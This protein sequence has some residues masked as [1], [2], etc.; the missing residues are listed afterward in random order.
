MKQYDLSF[1]DEPSR[2]RVRDRLAQMET[3][4]WDRPVNVTAYDT[5]SLA[6]LSVLAEEIIFSQGLAGVAARRA[7][8]YYF[9][10]FTPGEASHKW[11][12]DHI[13]NAKVSLVKSTRIST[14]HVNPYRESTQWVT[15]FFDV[16][17]GRCRGVLIP[18]VNPTPKFFEGVGAVET[19]L[20][21]EKQAPY[22]LGEQIIFRIL[23]S[24]LGYSYR[25]SWMEE[26]GI[27]KL[28][29]EAAKAVPITFTL[30]KREARE[31]NASRLRMAALT[32]KTWRLESIV[33]QKQQECDR[34]LRRM[35]S[36]QAELDTAVKA[37]CDHYELISNQAITTL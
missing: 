27:A 19:L 18:I 3:Q 35:K 9:R 22:Q 30:R 6:V 23:H 2:E 4:K 29:E 25:G 8:H 10:S 36:M 34:L 21:C 14:A 26:R 31:V 13:P 16:E 20:L 15:H 24:S 5:D 33:E 28:V 12:C 1:L 7:C 32:S 17:N 37:V 11:A